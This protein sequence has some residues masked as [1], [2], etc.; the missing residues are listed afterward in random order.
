M[1]KVVRLSAIIAKEAQHIILGDMLR[2]ILHEGFRAVPEGGDGVAI[3]V[4]TKDKAVFLLLLCHQAERVVVDV[5]EQLDG[6]LHT[7][8]VLIVEHELLAKE[9]TRLEATHVTI[10]LG[11]AVDDLASLHVLSDLLCLILVDPLGVGPV[12]LRNQAV[13]GGAGNERGGD[14]LEGLVEWLVV[15]ED[16]V[17][18]EAA[19]E[20]ILN[21]ADRASDFPNIAIASEGN[22]GGIH[23]RAGSNGVQVGQPTS[24]VRHE[25]ERELAVTGSRNLGDALIGR[26]RRWC[27]DLASLF[28]GIDMD[29]I[30][31]LDSI[32]MVLD[33]RPGPSLHI[34][35]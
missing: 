13:V 30:R 23:T 3:L 11:V 26:W 21:L 5:A 16:P 2:M 17:V 29:G 9:E 12:L 1:A 31:L 18:V 28:L 33:G 10:T 14:L 20:A 35:W 8:V 27:L 15:Q 22:K 7:P 24:L 34:W 19:V 32:G 25:T 6:G 4:Q